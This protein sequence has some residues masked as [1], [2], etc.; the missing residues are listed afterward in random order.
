[1]KPL[2]LE[3]LCKQ[4]CIIAKQA[5]LKVL[6]VYNSDYDIQKKSD[7]TPVTTAD[8]LAHELIC[9]QLQN[10][11]P[12]IPVL[13][14]ES[15]RTPYEIR[16]T[17][18]RYWLVDPLDGTREFIKHNDEFTVNIALIENTHSILGVIYVPVTG[19]TYYAWQRGGAHKIDEAGINRIIHTRS[20]PAVP[21]VSGS[22]S[23]ATEKL[24]VFLTRLG[25]I[26]LL[27]IGSS[28]KSCMVAEGVVDL[29]PRLGLTSEWDTAAAQCIVEEAGGRIVQT[30]NQPLR[31]NTKDSLLNPEFFVY[32]DPSHD[33]S[34]Y[35]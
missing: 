22:R 7:H 21:V 10:L 16:K 1:M 19:H 9:E 20:L 30:N 33:W 31:Y 15:T 2:D 34:K 14:E 25:E 12:D 26:E 24:Q 29:Y 17:W 35:L 23:H 8:L 5:G 18:K 11:T 3:A 32:G 27:S 13:S 4:S 6:E 28:L